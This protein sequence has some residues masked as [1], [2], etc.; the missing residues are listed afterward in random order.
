LDGDG[1]FSKTGWFRFLISMALGRAIFRLLGE[2]IKETYLG[3]F[4]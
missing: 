3:L 2:M 4:R 1:V